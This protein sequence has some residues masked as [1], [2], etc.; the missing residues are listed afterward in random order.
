MSSLLIIVIFFFFI[1][2]LSFFVFSGVIIS[3]GNDPTPIP[4]GP[5][6]TPTPTPDPHVIPDVGIDET[7]TSFT[8]IFKIQNDTLNYLQNLYLLQLTKYNPNY[9]KKVNNVG[10]SLQSG[11]YNFEIK[12]NITNQNYS[13]NSFSWYIL[14]SNT[15]YIDLFTY[16]NFQGNGPTFLKTSQGSFCT[17]NEGNAFLTQYEQINQSQNSGACPIIVFGYPCKTN[18]NNDCY[19]N[20]YTLSFDIIVKNADTYYFSTAF[21]NNGS[22]MYGNGEFEIKIIPPGIDSIPPTPTPD[23]F[24]PAPD[25][26]VIPD[27]GIDETT[28]SF[29]GIF[30]IQ[31]DTLN[32]LQNLYLLQLTKYNPN[33]IK[34]VNNVGL[35]LQSGKYNFEIKI[36]I[37][38]Q[39]YSG[40]SFS[41]YILLSNTYYIDLFT[42]NNFQGNGPTFL[43]TSQGSFCTQ[44]G[45]NAF[46]TQYEQINQS[47]NSDA[48]PI[49]VF[50]YPC[51]TNSNND[52]FTNYYT[53]S[54]DIIVKNKDTYYF[55]TAFDKGGSY[56]YGNG[57][58]EI[59]III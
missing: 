47:Q 59:K 12:I 4:P 15:Y 32:Y 5:T 25:P 2:F 57:E 38:N 52:C 45:G 20:Y 36:N 21:D 6:P 51:K 46:L 37:T 40:N 7:T 50:G 1:I 22:Y 39:N 16:N 54:F 3:S 17:K 18:S 48:C 28:T 43:K 10:L 34:K 13:G 29:T 42:Y 31:N 27:V 14:L 55:S 9:I 35:S 24:I 8:G 23:P 11:K 49:I 53:L 26:H 19:T 44:N 33:Y 56:M 58:F 30:K 41:W